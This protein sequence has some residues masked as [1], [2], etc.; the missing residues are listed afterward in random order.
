MP[1]SFRGWV[2]ALFLLGHSSR[3]ILAITPESGQQDGSAA[4]MQAMAAFKLSKGLHVQLFA[5]EPQIGN[6]VAIG[7]DEQ[8]RIFVAEEY[9]FNRGTEE[10]RTRPFLLVDDLQLQTVED[11]L[12][13]Y[14]KFASKFEGGM[15][16]FTKA[17]DQVRLLEDRD[18]DGRADVAKVF[19]GNFNGALDGLAAGVMA[20]NGDVYLTCIPNLW[21][22]RDSDGDGIADVRKVIH[23][24]FGVNAAFLG[25]DLH[26][27][28]WG[29][30]GRLYFSIGDRGFHVTTKE[31]TLLHGPRTGAVFRCEPDGSELE[32]IHRGLRNPQELAFDNYGNLFADDNN[33]DKGDRAR[34]VYVVEGGD[35]GWNMSNQTL[36]APYLTGPWH[37][38]KIWHLADKHQ[39]AWIVP[40]VGHLGAGPSGFAHYP[41]MG[42]SERYTNHFF[43]CN[44]TGQNGGIESFAVEPVG[45]G[46]AIVDYH[47]F[48]KPLA[49][50]D[51]EFGYDGKLHIS[52]LPTL[53][54]T[55]KGSSG[56]LYTA[57]DP[58]RIKDERIQEVKR[59]MR[60]GF[61]KRSPEELAP[62][63]NHADQRVRQRAQ[64]ALAAR[65]VESIALLAKLAAKTETPLARRHAIW[66]LWQI[67]RKHSEALTSVF[68]LLAD[69]DP[70]TRAQAARVIGDCRWQGA[71][72]KLVSMV[73]DANS[74][75]RFFATIALGHLKHR[76]AVEPILAMLRENKNEDPY[77]RH[78]GAAAIAE[79]GDIDAVLARSND[80]ESAVRLAVVL[81]LR[82]HADPRIAR[83]L[84]DADMNVVTEAARAINDLAIDDVLPVL[85]TH[86]SR[87]TNSPEHEAFV[88]RAINAHFRQGKAE[89]AEVLA[90]FLSDERQSLPMRTE[91]LAALSDW[92]TPSP[93]DRVT[94]FW[95]PLEPRAPEV[96]R[97]VLEQSVPQILSRT[98]GDL[99]TAAIKLIIKLDIKTDDDTF[100]AWTQDPQR[101]TATRIE[102]L[103][104]LA[105]RN[106]GKLA[107]A[108]K[109]SLADTSPMLRAEAR[110]VLATYDPDQAMVLIDSVLSDSFSPVVE[111]QR[112]LQ[113]LADL[114]DASQLLTKWGE[115]LLAGS[116]PDE[117]QL[118]VWEALEARPETNLADIVTRFK[119]TM[120][121]LPARQ[122]KFS[123][124]LAG[125]DA[126]R[127]KAI[128]TGHSTAQC[129]RCH[130]IR[131]EGGAAGPDLTEVAKRGQRDYL[132]ASMID[133]N[134]KIAQGYATVTLVLDTGK[135][136]AGVLKNE[137]ADAV[138]IETPD[139]TQ[140]VVPAA[141]IDE[142]TMPTSSMPNME[143]ALTPREVRDLVE[144][145]STLK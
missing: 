44:Y 131:G 14:K 110:Q 78:A 13:M 38:E 120:L 3:P 35:S 112:G 25:H 70:E 64:F 61:D 90:S 79:I 34:L 126:E 6:P 117:L 115:R 137:T 84:D 53:D 9:R 141:E 107:A 81:V 41:G 138:T 49:A 58:E 108:V 20:H 60:E 43:M 101:P 145:L 119:T 66:G 63:L 127:G 68:G 59:L 87:G 72:D 121:K 132:L 98:N 103:R 67:G 19:A 17:A 105:A 32:V 47:D 75:V 95:R 140:V 106:Y 123:V 5:A 102:A 134:A 23:T 125:G 77:L 55:G 28:C 93:R 54:W 50:T 29:P 33:C 57:Y 91:A 85:A 7:V 118:D 52:A 96:I 22:L 139:G 40:A 82:R 16:W 136:V 94:G 97:G 36:V 133:P 24:G 74:R 113:T 116:V 15:D 39:P 111:R 26:G 114:K 135:L 73:A 21:L 76:P 1:C 99:Q 71:N 46:F 45:A 130:K 2:F 62:L 42:L 104:L 100:F 10:N 86:L 4:A 83:F 8:G 37:A 80:T 142:R 30:D 48:M 143:R 56:R 124:S 128:F 27:L 109:T 129:V 18:G 11:R 92:T 69:A 88:R 12:D 89:N 31:G 144:Y 65:G 51:I 122:A